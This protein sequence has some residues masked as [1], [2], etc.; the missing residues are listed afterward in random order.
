MVVADSGNSRIQTY[1]ANG[2]LIHQFGESGEDE[3]QLRNPWGIH[4]DELGDVYVA[5]WGNDRVQVFSSDGDVKMV[6]EGKTPDGVA[7][8][9]PSSVTV[10]QHGDIYITDWT[11]NRVLVYDSNGRYVWRFLGDATLSRVARDYMMTNAY[12]NRL[13][14]MTNLEE[15]KYFR[16]PTSVRVDNQF[17][18][19]VADHSSY[20]LQ[21]YQKESVELDV[22]SIAP[23]MRNHSLTTV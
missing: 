4:V 16:N 5:D 18:I 17:R 13:R 10:D 2:K 20:R 3:G 9:R 15:E 7:I 23:P 8:N 22:N 6:L 14:E 19:C 21:V 11:N 1:D 12:A